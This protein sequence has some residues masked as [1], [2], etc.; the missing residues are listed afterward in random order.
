MWLGEPALSVRMMSQPFT[1]YFDASCPLC[2]REIG[3]YQKRKGAE[4]IEWV[5]VSQAENAPADLSCVQAMARFHVRK[6]NGDLVDGGV[7]FA[8]LWTQ[9]PAFR[10]LGYIF[11][12][13][14]FRGLI[15][16][17]YNVFLPIRPHLQRLVRRS[18]NVD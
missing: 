5:D 14:P 10:G 2:Q 11:T 8:E 7:A 4:A 12:K 15:N 18:A 3:F 13:P 16:V 9:L 6:T 1:V 17:A